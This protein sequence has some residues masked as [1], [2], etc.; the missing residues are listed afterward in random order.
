MSQDDPQPTTTKSIRF[1]PNFITPLIIILIDSFKLIFIQHPKTFLLIYLA[2]ALPL[3]V[4]LVSL[5]LS[6]LPRWLK[7]H[8]RRLDFLRLAV[9][10][11]VEAA[12]V[13][14]TCDL[15][16]NRLHRFKLLHAAPVFAFSLLTLSAVSAA[17]AGPGRRRARAGP[18]AL[19]SGLGPAR[20]AGPPATAV[21]GAAFWI[22]WGLLV[23]AVGRRLPLA[24]VE[25]YAMSV[26]G[27]SMVVSAVEGRAGADA[28][29]AGWGIMTGRRVVGW[30][31]SG[32][33]LAV[34]NLI[35]REIA[36]AMDGRD[37]TEDESG[38]GWR[39]GLRVGY[40]VGLVGV[41]T[42]VIMWS[43]VVMTVYYCECR[44]RNGV[45]RQDDDNVELV[46]VDF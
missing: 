43:Y 42:W 16:L 27:L 29:R 8:I 13:L 3:S 22:P 31:L 19:L 38:D 26:L 15:D 32:M 11:W 7:L 44:K 1:V 6:S 24:A 2:A 35:G 5:S 20:W 21:V 18:R 45:I 37:V 25:V 14:E 34:T 33:I 17:A 23:A 46:D 28:I 4:S 39:T 30:V 9:D 41:L 36:R 12:N 40:V 10:I